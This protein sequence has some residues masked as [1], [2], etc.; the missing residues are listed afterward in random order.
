MEIQ[1]V[2]NSLVLSL[3]LAGCMIHFKH[4]LPTTEEINSLKQYILTQGDTPWNPS[5][6]SDQVADMF[7]QQVIDN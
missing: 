5:L 2:G 3:E 7:H 1:D 4:R 6:F